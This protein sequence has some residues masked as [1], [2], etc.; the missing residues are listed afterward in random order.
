MPSLLAASRRLV[1]GSAAAV[2]AL[3]LAAPTASVAQ[4]SSELGYTP[5]QFAPQG[6]PAASPAPAPAAVPAAPAPA[7][8]AAATPAPAPAQTP[9][10]LA[11][12]S[13]GQ[14]VLELEQRLAGLRYYVGAVDGTYDADTEAGVMAYQKTTGMSR[15]GRAT[16]DVI[17]GINA[18]T[19][20]PPPLVPGGGSNR[21]EIDLTRQVLFLYKGDSLAAILPVSTGSGER[22]C[23]SGWCRNAVTNT[24]SFRVYRRA[25]GWETSPLGRLYNPLYFDGGIAVHGSLSVPPHPASHGCVRIPMGAA[26][27]FPNEVPN[28]TPVHVLGG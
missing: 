9:T 14:A 7:Q 13:Q 23:S 28:G 12:G 5:V 8:P 2:T 26:E 16:P 21:V 3:A 22:F 25:A 24:G 20:P 17:S 4:S 1:A 11:K 27:W 10:E 15:N 18:T 6:A 19:T